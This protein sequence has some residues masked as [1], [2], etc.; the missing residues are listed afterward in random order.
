MIEEDR[1]R[2]P[3]EEAS[4]EDVRPVTREVYEALILDIWPSPA[5]IVDFGLESPAHLGA[6]QHAIRYDDV[7]IE[8]LDAALGNGEALQALVSKTNPY[9]NARFRTKWD[10]IAE[11]EEMVSEEEKKEVTE[12]VD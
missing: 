8:Q 2:K 11:L 3:E 1:N 12:I 6:L 10:E 7:T 5:G 4:G 9:R